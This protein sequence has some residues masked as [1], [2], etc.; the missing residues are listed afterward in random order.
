MKRSERGSRSYGKLLAGFAL[1]GA[2]AGGA[3]FVHRH[4]D[5]EQ[6]VVPAAPSNVPTAPSDTD[7]AS[8]ALR[9]K[10]RVEV[11]RAQAKA[12]SP[13]AGAAPI[14]GGASPAV[15]VTSPTSAAIEKLKEIRK[16]EK[17]ETADC[18]VGSLLAKEFPGGYHD[19]LTQGTVNELAFLKALAEDDI[20]NGRETSVPVAALSTAYVKH[21][22][23]NVREQALLLASLLPPKDAGTVVA[24]AARAVRTTVSGPLTTQALRLMAQNRSA[25]PKLIDGTIKRLLRTGGWDQRE[26]VAAEILPFITRENRD[27]FAKLMAK[28]PVRSKVALHLRLGLEEFDRMERL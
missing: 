28:A 25:N 8:I 22:D 13:A 16:C 3:A 10:A 7:S 11:A 9:A 26:A 15:K 6:V 4:H 27:S 5:R 18:P 23:D 14:T 12:V 20:Q 2:L 21:P 1:A 24:V 17:V 19:L